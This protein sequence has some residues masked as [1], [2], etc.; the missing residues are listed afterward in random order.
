MNPREVVVHV[1]DCNRR[2]MVLNFLRK[3]VSQASKSAHRHSYRQ[4]L[5][6]DVAQPRALSSG[7][8][9]EEADEGVQGERTP[10]FRRL[11]IKAL[12]VNGAK[13]KIRC[14]LV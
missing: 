9:P 11:A 4:V 13:R 7:S 6:L 1:V 14:L 5:A 10:S 8:W 12:R 2:R 3:P